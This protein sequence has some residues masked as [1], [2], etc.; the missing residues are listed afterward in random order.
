MARW[1]L[2]MM[3]SGGGL[4]MTSRVWDRKLNKRHETLPDQIENVVDLHTC[5]SFAVL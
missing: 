2:V 4:V 3:I 5:P 1:W